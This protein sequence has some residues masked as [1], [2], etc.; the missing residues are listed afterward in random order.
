M[1]TKAWLCRDKE[2]SGMM[3]MAQVHLRRPKFV[4][5]GWI[6]ALSGQHSFIM[7]CIEEFERIFPAIPLKPGECIQI[8]IDSRLLRVVKPKVRKKPKRKEVRK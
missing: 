7:M 6:P 5:D 4:M 3:S 2:Y 1:K 8:E